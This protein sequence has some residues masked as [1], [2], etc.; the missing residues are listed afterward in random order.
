MRV[1]NR[2]GTTAGAAAPGS[3][4]VQGDQRHARPSRRRPAAA[5]GR[6]SASARCCA[7]R[8]RSP[9]SAATSSPSCCRW[10]IDGGAADRAE[11]AATR[12]KRRASS[13][14]D[15][16]ACGASMGIACFPEHG[17][18]AETLLQRADIAMYIAKTRRQRHRRLRARADGVHAHR[19]L[20]LIARIAQ[21]ARRSAVRPRVPAEAAPARA[22]WS[23]AWRRSC[24]GITRSA[25]ASCRASSSLW[26]SR[27][28]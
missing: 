18:S 2:E 1:A 22:T 17:R 14:A 24:A 12:S 23:S 26:P 13:M 20:T 5:V 6:R 15:R 4:R 21:S 11:G 16:S 27:P 10:P 25:G 8:T 19:R 28:G 7:R 3:E 9:A